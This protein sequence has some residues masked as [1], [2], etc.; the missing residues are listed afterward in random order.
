MFWLIN[1]Y[2]FTNCYFI[3]NI[4]RGLGEKEI[5]KNTKIGLSSGH[6]GTNKK[7]AARFPGQLRF[8]TINIIFYVSLYLSKYHLE[9]FSFPRRSPVEPDGIRRQNESP[10]RLILAARNV[11][12]IFLSS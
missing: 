5:T 6:M 9:Y 8:Y 1:Y 10:N 12:P 3:Q 7:I 2:F 11:L 4:N